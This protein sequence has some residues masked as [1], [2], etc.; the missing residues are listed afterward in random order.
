[1]DVCAVVLTDHVIPLVPVRQW[2]LSLPKRLRYFP[3]HNP[4]IAGGILRVFLRAVESFLRKAAAHAD[5]GCAGPAGRSGAGKVTRFGAVG[6][7]HR[8]GSALN[9]NSHY[10]CVVTDGV[11]EEEP[12]GGVMFREASAPVPEPP[13]RAAALAALQDQV[14]RRVLA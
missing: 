9:E 7:L 2:V 3:A 14:R 10:H 13:A 5:G 1:M 4:K 8:F 12:G 11:F 6:F